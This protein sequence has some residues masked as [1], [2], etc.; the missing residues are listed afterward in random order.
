MSEQI[1]IDTQTS[2]DLFTVK[3]TSLCQ[4]VQEVEFS[5]IN[6]S[7]EGK[8]MNITAIGTNNGWKMQVCPTTRKNICSLE[9]LNR[10]GYGLKALREIFIVRLDSENKS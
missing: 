7:E 6:L 3:D 8:A 4:S 9:V 10:R 1:W 5:E 2:A